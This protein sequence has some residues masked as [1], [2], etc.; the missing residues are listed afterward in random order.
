[1]SL[2]YRLIEIQ[3]QL[4]QK[5]PMISPI[6]SYCQNKLSLHK[7]GFQFS[8]KITMATEISLSCTISDMNVFLHFTKKFKANFREKCKNDSFLRKFV[9]C[10]YG[11][12]KI[13][14]KR[15]GS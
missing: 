14:W 4:Q 13:F 9:D 5:Q 10:Q 1:M 11:R 6:Y 8:H 2:I 3:S 15:R 7:S 12:K